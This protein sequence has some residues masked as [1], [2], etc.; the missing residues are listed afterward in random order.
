MLSKFDSLINEPR[1]TPWLRLCKEEPE[2]SA[3]NIT[4]PLQT[5]ER[6][7]EGDLSHSEDYGRQNE[8]ATRHRV[9][10][11]AKN[12]LLGVGPVGLRVGDEV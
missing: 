8:P 12:N 7:G 9:V 11:R 2:Q 1:V 10:F 3:Y 4:A 6:I 5:F